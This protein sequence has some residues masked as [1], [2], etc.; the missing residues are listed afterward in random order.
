MAKKLA[1]ISEREESESEM[2]ETHSK[3][4]R[5]ESSALA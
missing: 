5:V 3:S 4:V 1:K 2:S